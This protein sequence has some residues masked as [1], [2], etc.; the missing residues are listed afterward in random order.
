MTCI[1]RGTEAIAK[2]L[3]FDIFMR[4]ELFQNFG[5]CALQLPTVI[6]IHCMPSLILFF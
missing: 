5:P 1:G 6:K 2:Y 4:Q 3:P